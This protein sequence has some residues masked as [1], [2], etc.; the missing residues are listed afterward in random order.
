MGFGQ[1]ATEWIRSQQYSESLK[2]Y[3]PKQS[4][5]NPVNIKKDYNRH[6]RVTK[7]DDKFWKITNNDCEY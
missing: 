5:R 3:M 1:S 6:I 7:F 4:A 2:Y